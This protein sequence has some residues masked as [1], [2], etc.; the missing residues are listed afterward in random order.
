VARK[1]PTN[2]RSLLEAASSDPLLSGSKPRKRVN[3]RALVLPCLEHE[4]DLTPIGGNTL[5]S[6]GLAGRLHAREKP[7]EQ[8]AILRSGH[9][10][11]LVAVTNKECAIKV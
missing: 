3:A 8:L 5:P 10:G 6:A 9:L 11:E 2:S 1:S 4:C 7:L